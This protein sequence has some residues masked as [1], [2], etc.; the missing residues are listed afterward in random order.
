MN[1]MGTDEALQHEVQAALKRQ[2]E[3][4][5]S[6]IGVAVQ[7]GIVTLMGTVEQYGKKEAAEHAAAKVKGVKGIVEHI[8]V[9]RQGQMHPTD[10]EI[11][12][13][14]REAYKWRWD[15]PGPQLRVRVED[16]E[17]LLDG[18]VAWKYQKEAARS[19]AAQLI[20]VKGVQDRIT[21]C[22]P[23]GHA[24]RVRDVE[25]ILWRNPDIDDEDIHVEA[26]GGRVVLRGSVPTL[27]QKK[28]AGRMA[29]NAPGV[30]EV[31]NLLRII[32]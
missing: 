27:A 28:E 7:G 22:P 13:A 30:T 32:R 14:I 1:D 24:V 15:I 17:V 25:G 6:E 16:G 8:R 5:V 31:E 19:A 12:M 10:A 29:W 23:D 9:Q 3:L 26:A 11:A 21:V 4:S 18:E 20:G 2:P